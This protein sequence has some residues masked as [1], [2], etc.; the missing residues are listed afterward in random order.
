MSRQGKE[1]AIDHFVVITGCSGGGKSVLLTALA[2]RGHQVVEEPGRRLMRAGRADPYR[3]LASFA[4]AA[5]TMSLEDMREAEQHPGWVFFDR[6][7]IDAA[8][9]LAFTTKID[10][11]ET[12]RGRSRFHQTVFF[13][14]PWQEIFRPDDERQ[15]SF[16]SAVDEALRLKAAYQALGYQLT[17]LPKTSVEARADWVLAQLGSPK[18]PG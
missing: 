9:A 1:R 4:R 6:G 2:A 11:G 5:I 15:H 17:E 12:L 8:A 13:A 16:P 3:D 7:L 18:L 10:L 14:P